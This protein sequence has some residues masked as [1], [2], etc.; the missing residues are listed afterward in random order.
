MRWRLPQQL[1]LALGPAAFLAGLRLGGRIVEDARSGDLALANELSREVGG[2]VDEDE[3]YRTAVAR[4]RR[5]LAAEGVAILRCDVPRGR[6]VLVAAEGDLRIAPGWVQPLDA[7]L[8]G[9]AAATGQAVVTGDARADPR[10]VLAPGMEH[11]RSEVVIP[12]RDRDGAVHAVLDVTSSRPRRFQRAHVALLSTVAA[13]LEG[14]VTAASLYAR[15]A[16]RASTDPLTGLPNH[17]EFKER[18]AGE[19]RS[20]EEGNSLSLCLIDLDRFKEINDALGHQAGDRLLADAARVLAANARTGEFLARIG[21]D[22]FAWILPRADAR[23]ALAAAERTR[24]ALA[25]ALA[26]RGTSVSIGICDTGHATDADE[27]FRLA[28][29]ALYWAKS[30]GRDL[31][32]V[33]SSEVAVALSTEEREAHAMRRRALGGLRALARAVDAKDP[34][35]RDHSGRVA[36]LAAKV[37]RRLGWAEDAVARLREAG[38]LHDVG[39][40]GVPDAILRKPGRLTDEEMRAVRAHPVLGAQIAGEVLSAEQVA[41]IRGHHERWDGR[42]YPDGL[43]G[44]AI[45]SGARILAAADAWDAMTSLRP[46]RAALDPDHAW[47]ELAASAGSQLCPEAAAAL[48]AVLG[49]S[50]QADDDAGSAATLSELAGD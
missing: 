24:T 35:T 4:L 20:G 46:Y 30:Q 38:M 8:L 25:D 44:A 10:C 14:A 50:G 15:L 29:G 5:H 33:Y 13:A 17:R 9:R 45:P 1:G 28:D 39:K 22:E 47:Q 7:G 12:I 11:L 16:A 42:G 18:L 3:V 48:G 27:L 37:A 21:G 40:I 41:W 31:C 23:G 34:S 32:V 19:L 2:L 26:D 43:A 6:F 36:D 49:R